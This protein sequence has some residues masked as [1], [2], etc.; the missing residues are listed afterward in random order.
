M[1]FVIIPTPIILCALRGG[2]E[3]ARSLR[4]GLWGTA[5]IG[6]TLSRRCSRSSPASIGAMAHDEVLPDMAVLN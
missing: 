3:E 4:P 2:R 1:L 5:Y 6:S